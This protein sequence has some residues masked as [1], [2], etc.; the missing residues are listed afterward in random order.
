MKEKI[1]KET[2]SPHRRPLFLF[3]IQPCS[4]MTTRSSETFSRTDYIN[5]KTFLKPFTQLSPSSLA[6]HINASL[7]FHAEEFCR[8]EKFIKPKIEKSI[9]PKNDFPRILRLTLAQ[10]INHL[11]T[12]KQENI[13]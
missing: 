9:F 8:E 6:P 1:K 3:H 13:Q 7:I 10:D 11:D 12:L 5:E 4:H 2:M